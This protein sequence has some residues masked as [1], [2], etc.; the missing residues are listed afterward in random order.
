MGLSFGVLALGVL[1]LGLAFALPVPMATADDVAEAGDWRASVNSKV[2]DS[3]HWAFTLRGVEKLGDTLKVSLVFR[4]NASQPRPLFLEDDFKS[5]IYLTDPDSNQRFALLS[6]DGISEQ[7][8][9]VGRHKSKYAKF[10]FEYPEGAETVR[11]SSKWITMLMRG[12]ATV[13]EVEFDI[14]L[15]PPGAKT[16]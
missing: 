6:A 9:P 4:N 8:T 11:F 3:S 2:V 13:I 12:T 14:P 10:T 16:S 1:A 5:R 7:I 15:P